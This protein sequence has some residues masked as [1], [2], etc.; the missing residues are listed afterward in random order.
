MHQCAAEEYGSQ[1]HLYYF[2]CIAQD[3]F[4]I[5]VLHYT[6]VDSFHASREGGKL[7]KEKYVLIDT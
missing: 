7:H 5:I 4:C 2:S 1:G 3:I 6:V